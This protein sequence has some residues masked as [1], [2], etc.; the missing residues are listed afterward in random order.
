MNDLMDFV[1]EFIES[2]KKE[3]PAQAEAQADTNAKQTDTKRLNEE[4]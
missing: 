2:T 1:R 3:V 4:E